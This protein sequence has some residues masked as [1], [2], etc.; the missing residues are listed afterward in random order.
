MPAVVSGGGPV[1][2]D[3]N[4]ANETG[5]VATSPLQ[6]KAMEVRGNRVNWQSYKQGQ[7]ITLEDY[8]V[9]TRLDFSSSDRES[10]ATYFK[11]NSNLA[12]KTFYKLIQH[13]AKDQTLQYLLVTIDDLLIEDHSRVEMFKNYALSVKESPWAGFFSLLTRS[14]GFIVNQ[15]S[16]II[17]KMACW[18]QESMDEK[19]RHF[20]VTWLRDQLRVP[21]NEYMQ[22]VCRCLQILL[23]LDPFR[24]IFF[25]IDG[26]S[27][28]ANVLSGRIGFQLQYQL[29][30]CLWCLTFN[31]DISSRLDKY[32]IIPI[33]ADILSEAVKDKVTRITLSTYRNLL[34]KPEEMHIK[35]QNA[36]SMVQCKLLKQLEILSDKKF[37]DVDVVDD[38]KFLTEFL[39]TSVQ[40]LSSF[41]EYVTE[42]KSGRLEWSPV[43]KEIRF[44]R[45]NASR[46][47]EG[48][49]ELL[50]TLI[51][52]LNHNHDPL[53]LSVAAH[54]I[55]EYVR[56]YPRG[57]HVLEQ[58]GGKHAVMKHL[59]HDDPNVRYEA[60]LSVQKLMVHNWEYLGK[61]IQPME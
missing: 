54:D 2:P 46:L 21:N 20:Y 41:D 45:E 50:R 60:L 25:E 56:H 31:E 16:A 35:Q 8:G 37:D 7:M 13:I 58:I 6:I 39:E 18:G 17:T 9:V 38:I 48:N 28:I 44:W 57:K 14:D 43:H 32:S 4:N 36:V 11:N 15:T 23:R 10:R 29:I 22:S 47:N 40:D 3:G 1:S 12:A 49:Y 33:L 52:L 24:S 27:T 59:S 34:E 61:A 51:H 42:V 26:V 5:G 53:I 19:N 55:G 30:F